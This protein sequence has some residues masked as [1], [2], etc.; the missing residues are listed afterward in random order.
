MLI[1][2][3]TSGVTPDIK[4][5]FS[6]P[7]GAT[8]DWLSGSE[9]FDND[10]SNTAN[11]TTAL[12]VQTGGPLETIATYFRIIMSSTAGDAILQW[13]QGTANASDTKLKQGS[14]LVVWEE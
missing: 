6:L 7:A 11:I 10:G 4:F 2:F 8:G 12:T 1:C 9:A 3:Y 14:F 13:A 5:A